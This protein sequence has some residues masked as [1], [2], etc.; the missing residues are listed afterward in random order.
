MLSLSALYS[1]LSLF[2][3]FFVPANTKY[4]EFNLFFFLIDLT[5]T[6]MYSD[7]AYLIN[8][9]SKLTAVKLGGKKHTEAEK[10]PVLATN[11]ICF[12]ADVE[13]W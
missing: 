1:L 13:Q 9:Y 6:L 5:F 7:S 8:N 3:L 2:L 11:T 12:W 4:S 10:Q